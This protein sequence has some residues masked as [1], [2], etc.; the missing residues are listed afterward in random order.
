[1]SKAQDTIA[2]M[3]MAGALIVGYITYKSVNNLSKAP[4]DV[5]AAVANTVEEVKKEVVAVKDNF[6]EKMTTPSENTYS[7]AGVGGLATVDSRGKYEQGVANFWDN[8]FS[9]FG[10]KKSSAPDSS[11]IAP[12]VSPTQNTETQAQAETAR[13]VRKANATSA[14]G[15]SA[16]GYTD[17]QQIIQSIPVNFGIID[18]SSW[19]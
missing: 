16:I 7:P 12:S 14:S 18:P 19:K 10:I 2:Y 8:V 1:M 3:E 13:L 17:S 9:L 4:G 15:S 6:I 5:V 11:N